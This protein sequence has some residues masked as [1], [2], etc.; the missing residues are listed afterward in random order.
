MSEYGRIR[1]YRLAETGP[2][3]QLFSV[4]RGKQL[5]GAI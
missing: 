2:I 5:D 4:E 1:H 3:P